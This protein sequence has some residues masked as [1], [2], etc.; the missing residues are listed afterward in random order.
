MPG[1]AWKKW[2]RIPCHEPVI[3]MHYSVSLAH[4]QR[5]L[6]QAEWSKYRVFRRWTDGVHTQII[7]ELL[8]PKTPF[9][10]GQCARRAWYPKPWRYDKKQSGYIPNTWL[11]S[12]QEGPCPF[13]DLDWD[14]N[15]ND[16]IDLSIDPATFAK[17][18]ANL[19]APT[20]RVNP[21]APPKPNFL[22]RILSM[23]SARTRT[24]KDVEPY[25]D[26]W[27]EG[28]IK[29]ADNTSASE[30]KAGKKTGLSDEELEENEEALREAAAAD[31]E[32]G[33]F[34]LRD[35]D[36]EEEDPLLHEPSEWDG[37]F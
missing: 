23:K 17:N 18:M 28:G 16:D 14:D 13:I 30:K 22:K 12:T 7:E 6:R 3:E 34:L 29:K 2:Y 20:K 36:G 11:Y 1:F 25:S 4:I 19:D 35:S 32:E 5:W 24:G 37:Q 9:R 26:W 21:S 10:L 15:D 31:D 8:S 27:Y 33:P